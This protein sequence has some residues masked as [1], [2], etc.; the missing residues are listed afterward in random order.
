MSTI[1]TIRNA[2]WLGALFAVLLS[3]LPPAHAEVEVLPTPAIDPVRAGQTEALHRLPDGNILVGGDF[4][5]LGQVA[6]AGCGRLLPDG[7]VDVDFVCAVSGARLFAHDDQGRVY[8]VGPSAFAVNRLLDDGSIDPAFAPVSTNG[9]INSL[10]MLDN[11]IHLAGG[12]TEVN[13]TPRQRLARLSLDGALDPDWQP[14]VDGN[15]LAAV[16]PGDGFLYVGGQFSSLNGTPRARLGRLSVADGQLDGWDAELASTLSG[17]AIS[18]M[19]HDGSHVY[20]SGAFDSVQG[21]QRRR[22][23]KLSMG[24]TATLDASWAPQV[25]SF[26]TQSAGPRLLRVLGNDVYVGDSGRFSLQ[27]DGQLLSAR[28]QRLSR[29]GAAILDLG[30]NPFADNTTANIAGPA[31]LIVGDGGGRLF[32]GGSFTQLSAGEVRMG[33]AALNADGSV[34][35]FSALVE[36]LRAANVANLAQDSS[37][38][39]LYVQGDF[40]RV[41]GALRQGLVRLFANGAVDSGF[42][43][44]ARTYTA[45]AFADGALYAAD[46]SNRQLRR[47]DP[48]SGEGEPDFMPIGYTGSINRLDAVGEHLYLLGSFQL[49]GITPALTRLARLRLSDGVI[50]TQFRF[51]ANAGGGIGGVALDVASDSL[52]LF[53]S[54]SSINEQ[55]AQHV[56]R[57]VASSLAI[58]PLFAPAIPTAPSAVVLDDRGGLWLNGNFTSINGQLC[59]APARLL[60][61]AD[62][63]LDP[64]FSCNRNPLGAGALVFQRDAVY[65]QFSTSLRRFALADAG[66]PDPNWLLSSAPSGLR[67]QAAS[68]R[69]L[70]HGSFDSL[71]GQ[72]RR[73]LAALAEAGAVFANGFE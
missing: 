66:S 60:L 16:A 58:D 6:A 37:S 32:V 21:V 50:D 34:D 61:D 39:A 17:F 3:M 24:S 8:V 7:S 51:S 70:V 57:V 30:F 36:S 27:S 33:L 2:A 48:Q 56:V 68:G 11:A 4:T 53:G 54:F 71:A 72:T 9:G 67:M 25:V 5:R 52:M 64:D 22:L 18:S 40:L 47:L 31:A 59:R 15:V 38:G 28:L 49:S 14:S 46:D 19:D 29:S 26:S 1:R 12:F 62:G 41:N 44:A 10:L 45:I 73:S 35:Q 23:A 43:P 20:L 13:G 69:L 42:R 55:P 65:G 63:A